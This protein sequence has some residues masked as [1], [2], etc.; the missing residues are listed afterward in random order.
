M[1]LLRLFR[2]R[3][4]NFNYDAFQVARNFFYYFNCKK[5]D[6]ELFL[7]LIVMNLVYLMT[8]VASVFLQYFLHPIN[9]V[10]SAPFLFKGNPKK[11]KHIGKNITHIL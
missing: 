1:A 6:T 5:F 3:V 7:S 9:P 11:N 8:C 10:H 2:Q 4:S